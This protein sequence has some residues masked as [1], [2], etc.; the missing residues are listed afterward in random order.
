[1]PTIAYV[2]LVRFLDCEAI[3]DH[4]SCIGIIVPST[5]QWL[6]FK[7]TLH[8]EY[9]KGLRNVSKQAE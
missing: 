9:N 3:E 6:G 7:C 2:C 8:L 1:M 5:P 4:G